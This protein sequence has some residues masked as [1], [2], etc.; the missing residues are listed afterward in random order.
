M[1]RKYCWE[2]TDSSIV[3]NPALRL[4]PDNQRGA[5]EVVQHGGMKWSYMPEGHAARQGRKYCR[6]SSKTTALAPRVHRHSAN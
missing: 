5:G 1:E 6:W 3:N 2:R 4:M